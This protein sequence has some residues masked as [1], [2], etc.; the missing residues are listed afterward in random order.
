MIM[1]RFTFIVLSLFIW[2]PSFAQDA[3]TS[4]AKE[5]WVF[6]ADVSAY[7]F[8]DDFFLLPVVTAD[9]NHLHLEARYNYEDEQTASLFG[10]YNLE[11]GNKFSVAITPIAGVAF[12]NTDGI[13]L[14]YE[15]ELTY[16]NLG[17]YSEGEYL[18]DLNESDFSFF[19]NWSELYYAPADWIWFGI[20]AQRL[21]E[22]DTERDLQRGVF[23]AL[24]RK[25]LTVTGYYFN[26]FTSDQF[27]VLTLGASF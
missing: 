23:L 16:W 12:G 19:Y 14:G 5:P 22:V 4:Q 24:Q 17:L 26:P 11:F 20:V 18:F 6:N 10:G 3:D 27:G 8:P 15:M 2:Q 7:F 9:H 1:R 21:R 25:W 13:V